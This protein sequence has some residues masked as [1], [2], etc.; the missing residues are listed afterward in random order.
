MT[1]KRNMERYVSLDPAFSTKR[2]AKLLNALIESVEAGDVQGF[3]TACRDYDQI[4]K[5]DNW[6][7]GIL[8]KIKKTIDEEPG[9]T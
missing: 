8:L 1:A 2:E 3:A 6:K 7:T 4:M 9:L 5:L